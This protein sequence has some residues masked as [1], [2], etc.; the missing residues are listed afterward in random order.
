[1][2]DVEEDTDDLTMVIGEYKHGSIRRIKLHNFL[3][4]GNVECCPGPRYVHA[5]TVVFRFSFFRHMCSKIW[6]MFSMVLSP[7]R[8]NMVVGPNGT[9]KSSILCAICL[10]L[11]GEPRL[12]GR[13]SEIETF[14]MNGEDEAR[15]EI[16]LQCDRSSDNPVITRVIRRNPTKDSPKSTFFVNGNQVSAKQVRRMVHEEYSISVDNLCTFLVSVAWQAW[17]S[18]LEWFP[19]LL[20]R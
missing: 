16:E 10:C 3:T 6:S 12:L 18:W 1:M 5:S 4:Y 2:S 19:G 13:A 17:L 7:Y 8:L 11:G 14:V 15:I 20:T 9:G